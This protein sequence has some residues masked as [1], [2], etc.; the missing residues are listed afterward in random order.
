MAGYDKHTVT[1]DVYKLADCTAGSVHLV[2][3]PA[4]NADTQAIAETALAV[5][6]TTSTIQCKLQLQ[7][8]M[9]V[10]HCHRFPALCM[11]SAYVPGWATAAMLA[12]AAHQLLVIFPVYVQEV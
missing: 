2:D 10:V 7:A 11:H 12:A 1:A 8:D 5:A 6:G 4:M 3:T 9:F